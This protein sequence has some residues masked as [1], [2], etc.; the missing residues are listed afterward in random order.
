MQQPGTVVSIGLSEK[1]SLQPFS[2]WIFNSVMD[3]QWT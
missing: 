2:L 1:M 3:R